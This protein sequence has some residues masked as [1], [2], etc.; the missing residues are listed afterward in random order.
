MRYERASSGA[1]GE[2][3]IEASVRA[4]G[5]EGSRE[6]EAQLLVDGERVGTT[7]VEVAPGAD[8]NAR[9]SHRVDGPGPFEV[10]V[11]VTGD[12]G[13]TVDDER[14]VPLQPERAVRALIVNGDARSVTLN[15]EAFFLDRALG[16]S[17]GGRQEIE[18]TMSVAIDGTILPDPFLEV[19][20][21]QS[22]I[23]ILP[24]IG[25]G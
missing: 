5:F 10:V 13:P 1:A 9:F 24:K 17:I 2:Y 22:E 11:R 23:Y 14:A 15:D 16:V 4:W 6:V 8:G 25:G 18:T 20:T 12:T 19:V 7:V 3:A 21:D